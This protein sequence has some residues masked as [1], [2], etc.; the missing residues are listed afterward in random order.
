MHRVE[1]PLLRRNAPGSDSGSELSISKQLENEA[2]H[3]IKYRSC[4]WH[5]VL[6]RLSSRFQ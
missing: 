1:A 3:T 2:D 5:K 4:S 6:S